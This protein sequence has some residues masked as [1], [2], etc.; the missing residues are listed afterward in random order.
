MTASLYVDWQKAPYRALIGTGGIG[1]GL[2]FAM[3]GNHTLGREESR[4]GR[5]LDR[6]DYCKLHII[7]HYVKVLLG[8]DFP[9][10]LLGKV[11]EDAA[12]RS[13]MDEMRRTGLDTRYVQAVPGEPTLLS[14]VF[15]Y[16]DGS[17]GNLTPENSA[18]DRVSAADI[19]R[20]AGEFTRW[21]G[22]GIALAAPEVL[23][24]ARREL[25]ELASENQFLRVGAFVSG[26]VQAA[27]DLGLFEMLD[28][29]ALNIDEAAALMGASGEE[30]ARTP[31]GAEA[32]VQA[33]AGYL[34]R[35]FPR[36]RLSLT[37]GRHGSW[38]WDG[39]ALA[40]LPAFPTR[41]VSTAG[42]GD[43]HLAGI[44]AGLTA[45]LDLRHAH[46][47]GSLVA[48]LS[49]TSPHTIA[50]EVERGALAAFARER[51]LPLSAEVG[52]LL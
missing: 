16:P 19:R 47:L 12:G 15:T 49:V 7:S 20:A 14:V 51:S 31:Q 52:A 48:A 30:G 50:P 36:L 3:T 5:F 28:L 29:L 23:L 40:H 34:S 43:A 35:R 33:A 25:L 37:A 1:A 27:L 46:E 39:S 6:R 22:R 45:G 21:R 2:F 41:V 11:G 4:A 18:C 13:L 38:S 32:A 42:A 10:I 8:A 26:E 17:G 24:S 44:I 9:A